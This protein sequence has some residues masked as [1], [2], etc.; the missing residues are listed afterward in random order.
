MLSTTTRMSVSTTTVERQAAGSGLFGRP[1]PAA[2]NPGAHSPL[3]CAAFFYDRRGKVTRLVTE[4]VVG[5]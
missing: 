4:V 1:I 3:E 5:N 2:S